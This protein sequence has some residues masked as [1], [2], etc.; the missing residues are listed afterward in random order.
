MEMLSCV[1][2][3]CLSGSSVG[4]SVA[5]VLQRLRPGALSVLRCRGAAG[6]ARPRGPALR[7]QQRPQPP[8]LRQVRQRLSHLAS[9]T[10]L[11]VLG[12]INR[13]LCVLKDIYKG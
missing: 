2:R 9:G 12:L 3:C 6:G 1:C 7:P 8:A 5:A 10:A 11:S 13:A 4:G